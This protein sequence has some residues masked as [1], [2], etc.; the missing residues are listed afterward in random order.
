MA[1]AFHVCL[2]CFAELFL[3][4]LLFSRYP[5]DVEREERKKTRPARDPIVEQ[6]RLCDD[7]EHL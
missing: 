4:H 1:G 5:E 7:P 3:H 2:V 6:E